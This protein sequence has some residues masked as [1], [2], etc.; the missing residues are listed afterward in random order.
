MISLHMISLCKNLSQFWVSMQWSFAKISMVAFKIITPF[1]S[2]YLCER[3]FS[4]L[5]QIKQKQG[6]NLICARLHMTGC[7]A[8][9]TENKKKLCAELQAHPSH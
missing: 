9:T 2:T 4:T 6:I 3:G 8:Y 1:V 7:F 5:V